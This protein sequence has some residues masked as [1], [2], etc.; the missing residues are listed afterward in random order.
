VTGKKE[1][2]PG[3]GEGATRGGAN[4]NCL[5]GGGRLTVS[6]SPGG[7]IAL[8]ITLSKLPGNLEKNKK[9][10]TPPGGVGRK[11]RGGN[12]MGGSLGLKG[13]NKLCGQISL[14]AKMKQKSEGT[15]SSKFCRHNQPG[16][17]RKMKP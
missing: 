3:F 17:L 4:E 7:A 15:R 1:E 13:P 2:R 9:N 6:T 12:L 10:K 5:F 14:K 16:R 11:C 8:L